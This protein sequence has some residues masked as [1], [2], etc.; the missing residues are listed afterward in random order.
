MGEVLRDAGATQTT[1]IPMGGDQVPRRPA[2]RQRSRLGRLHPGPAHAR[3]GIARPPQSRCRSNA[4]ARSQEIDDAPIKASMNTIDDIAREATEG[5]AMEQ[6]YAVVESPQDPPGNP[7]RLRPNRRR[8]DVPVPGRP[9]TAD[10]A[11]PLR[12]RRLLRLIT[13]PTERLVDLLTEIA[14]RIGGGRDY[15]NARAVTRL[16]Q[17][18]GGGK[19]HACIGAFH[20][21]A[22]PDAS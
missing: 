3:G 15:L 19:S 12:R 4:Q 17:G 21:A 22:N 10:A 8:P 5:S 9:R 2:S 6:A 20:L 7:R 16:D 11:R 1:T 13:H 14:I 18:M